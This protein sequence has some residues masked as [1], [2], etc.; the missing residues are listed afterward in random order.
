MLQ[1]GQSSTHTLCVWIHAV[2]SRAEWGIVLLK[3]LRKGHPLDGSIC[4]SKIPIPTSASDGAKPEYGIHTYEVIHAM[5]IFGMS[6]QMSV[7]PKSSWI[8]DSSDHRT[9]VHCLS[10][11]L[12]WGCGWE[13]SD[14]LYSVDVRPPLCVI[15]FQLTLLDTAADCVEW[16]WFVF[17]S[18]SK[19]FSNF[20]WK[21]G[22][23]TIRWFNCV[24]PKAQPRL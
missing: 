13:L 2:R 23:N 11:H 17:M 12:R 6:K 3:Q 1:A 24:A 21:W 9:H 20:L 14:V 8:V 18:F 7:F 19:E 5:D 15:Q 22:L 10:V 4:L 16:K